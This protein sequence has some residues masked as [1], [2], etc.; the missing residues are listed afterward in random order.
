MWHA[1]TECPTALS[2]AASKR[3]SQHLE[4]P[5]LFQLSMIFRSMPDPI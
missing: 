3:D 1:Y 5:W 2:A 4:A